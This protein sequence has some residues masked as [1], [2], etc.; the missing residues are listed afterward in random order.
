MP[1]IALLE[2]FV[3]PVRGHRPWQG[4]V[5]QLAVDVGSIIPRADISTNFGPTW[6]KK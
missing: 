3:Q 4:H 2:L 1:F 6:S 5:V